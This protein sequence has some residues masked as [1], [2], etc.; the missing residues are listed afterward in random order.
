[1]IDCEFVYGVIETDG[2]Q[3]DIG[4]VNLVGDGVGVIA[5]AAYTDAI[6]YFIAEY[7]NHQD[8]LIL[9]KYLRGLDGVQNLDIYT[10]ISKQ[11]EK[12]ELSKFHRRILRVLLDDPRMTIAGIAE[13]TR[14]TAKRVRKALKELENSDA[15]R[16]SIN[17]ELGAASDIPFILD[18]ATNDQNKTYQEIIEWFRENHGLAF[19]E[20]YCAAIEPKMF[21]LLTVDT[22]NEVNEITRDVR[23]QSFAKTVIARVSTY[24]DFF[25]GIRYEKMMEIIGDDD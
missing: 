2:S 25:P 14:L 18:I 9:G 19:W 6:Y 4:F 15:I 24:H 1:M 17:W 22:L 12:M 10:I 16:F 8:L 20:G 5:A 3:D 23:K 13:K 21:V 11:G 7:T